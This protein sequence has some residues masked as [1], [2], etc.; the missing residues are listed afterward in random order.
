MKKLLMLAL[1]VCGNVV[2]GESS[3]TLLKD[4][5]VLDA[6]INYETV[7]CSAVGYGGS[8]LKINIKALDGWTILDHT[9]LRFGERSGLP[10]MTAG[11]CKYQFSDVGYTV[12]DLVKNFPRIEKVVVNRELIETRTLVKIGDQLKC[13]RMLSESLNT[14]IGGI[15]F[16]HRR[17]IGTSEPLPQSAC[18]F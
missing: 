13:S 14:V 12:D 15:P 4:S 7:L 5:K 18:S 1:I 3:R 6:E 8:E 9:N 16:F 11:A 2:A 10:C 17:S